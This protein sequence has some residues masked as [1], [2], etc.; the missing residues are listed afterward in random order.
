MVLKRFITVAGMLFSFSVLTFADITK[1]DI[2]RAIDAGRLKHPY[3]YFS[4][5]DLP[6]IR[7]RAQQDPV[8]HDLVQQL[9]AE[10]NRLLYTPVDPTPPVLPKDRV[11]D[12][13][14]EF[15]N[16][17]LTNAD[18]GYDLAFAWL[19]TGEKEYALK[20][21][22]FLDVVCDIPTWVHGYHEFPVIYDRVWPWGAKDDQVVFSYAQWSDHLVLRVA[23]AY[24]WLYSALDRRQRDRLRG[25]LLEKAVLRVRGNYEYHWWAAAYRCNW[26]SVV[27]ASLGLAS[28]ALLTED[29][30]LTDVIAESYNRISKTFD[31]V[32]DGGWQEG[33]SY[34]HYTVNGALPFADAL[35]RVTDNR[36]NLYMHP[37]IDDVIDTFLY[38]SIPPDMTVHFS[39]CSGSTIGS[40]SF[41]NTLM[42]E[43]G[44]RKVA[45]LRNFYRYEQ[46]SSYVDLLKPVSTL[47]PDIPGEPS[48]HFTTVDWVI[49]RSDFTDPEK[50]VVAAKS[51]K[52]DDPH[53]G[54]LD[55]GHFSLYWRG[56]EFLCD[57][58]SGVQDRLYFYE[59]R[60]QNPFASSVGHNVVFVNGERQLPGKLKNRPW[61]ETVGGTV[62]E[63]RQG[64]DRDYVLMAPTNAYPKKEMKS[65][66]RHII[67]E[68]PVITVILDEITCAEGSEIEV[69]FHSTAKSVK[70]E[71][72]C[73]LNGDKGVMCLIPVVKGSFTFRSGKDSVRPVDKNSV[74][75]WL[76][77]FG[78]VVKTDMDTT[79]IG[80]LIL[81]IENESKA[82]K[83]AKS[84]AITMDNSG[85][86]TLSFVLGGK[87]HT[88]TFHD[89]KNTLLL[90]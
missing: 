84:T 36:Y 28:I 21:F 88:Y 69:R 87:T 27:N 45:W 65:W 9:L 57:N 85:N 80:T 2:D 15:E 14:W 72:Y 78:A 24:D 90:E 33:M 25:A 1:D 6:A 32:G 37:R 29:P 51:G 13:T 60:W 10:A 64:K 75:R 86:V 63:F 12:N 42:L 83:I 34:L 7:E 89:V 66:R 55:V 59:D 30:D 17:V 46:P 22:E 8:C 20:A 3:L 54:H 48:K 23:A 61:D 31:Q 40:Y 71:R 74:F 62:V 26:C 44:N 73:L 4:E 41:F 56:Q 53:H 5:Q 47:E 43:T 79:C 82:E 49:M 50:V 38:C 11:Y 77:Y 67:L 52:N 68:K 58:G 18:R 70:T 81:P 19:I 16:F 35:K 76:P 39:D